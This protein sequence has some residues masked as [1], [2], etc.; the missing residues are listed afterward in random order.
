MVVR[1]VSFLIVIN[2]NGKNPQMEHCLCLKY[3]VIY[4]P[5]VWNLLT[6]ENITERWNWT[7][8]NATDS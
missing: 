5:D 8:Q 1:L 3:V 2:S 7:D 4:R 6:A